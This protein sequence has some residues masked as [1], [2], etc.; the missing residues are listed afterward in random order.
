[1]LS[2]SIL[3]HELGKGWPPT[4]DILSFYKEQLSGDAANLVSQISSCRGISQE[5]A[6]G[7]LVDEAAAAHSRVLMT[8][9]RNSV[10]LE[11][12]RIFS[13]GYVGFHISFERYKLHE[14]GM[15][16]VETCPWVFLTL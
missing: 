16:P 2:L 6:L 12:Y 3:L 11:A 4:S 10:A 1:M 5:A 15:E 8:L 14:L 13:Q 9:A 7:E